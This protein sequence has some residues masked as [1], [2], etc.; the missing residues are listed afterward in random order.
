[1]PLKT[2]PE[3]VHRFFTSALQEYA[4]LESEFEVCLLVNEVEVPLDKI[5]DRMND[6]MHDF[7]SDEVE[8]NVD[9]TKEELKGELKAIIDNLTK[10]R[11]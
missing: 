6:S 2:M 4:K 8:Y 7:V 5:L 3:T 9:E 11:C 1:M 10:H